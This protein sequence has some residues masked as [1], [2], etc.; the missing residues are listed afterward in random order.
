MYPFDYPAQ[1]LIRRHEPS[2]YRRYQG[3]KPWLRD[4]FCF[5]CIYCLSRER[6]SPLGSEIFSVEHLK[7]KA[8]H[9]LLLLVYSN[10]AYACVRCNRLRGKA[11]LQHDPCAAGLRGDLA[12][13]ADG[14]LDSTTEKGKFIIRLLRLNRKTLV[15]FRKMILAAA[16]QNKRS[17]QYKFLFGFPTEDL[18]N[19]ADELSSTG[20]HNAKSTSVGSCYY[21]Q[22]HVHRALPKTF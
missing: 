5:T 1:P 12:V 14:R 6:W 22:Y 3:F 15:K 4:E 8:T 20:I 21:F 9:P 16:S 10:L 2:G 19:L 18:P 11:D 13:Q 7:P 17:N